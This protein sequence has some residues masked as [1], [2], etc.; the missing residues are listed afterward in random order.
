M[1]DRDT[2]QTAV[3]ACAMAA[4]IVSS[5][6]VPLI[7]D[8]LAG[9]VERLDKKP[10]VDLEGVAKA[11]AAHEDLEVLQSASEL[12]KLGTKWRM[13]FPIAFKERIEPPKESIFR[14]A[15]RTFGELSDKERKMI[16]DG[17]CLFCGKKGHCN[18]ARDE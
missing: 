11:K 12:W 7:A 4:H 16:M 17:Y 18:C 13:E 2:Y 5:H 1:V 15:L 9:A 6:N 10:T 3:R 14:V 8:E